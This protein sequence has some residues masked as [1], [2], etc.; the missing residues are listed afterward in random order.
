MEHRLR[1]PRG[2]PSLDRFA[3]VAAVAVP[4][5]WERRTG[6][7]GLRVRAATAEDLMPMAER[8]RDVGARRQLAPLAD[9]AEL[10]AWIARAPG[11]HVSDYLLAHDARGRLIG[12]VGVWDQSALKQM[13]V[14]GYSPRL[15]LARHAINLAAPLAGA[16]RL[17][18]PGGVLP[19]LAAVHLC[20]REPAV[21]RA[22]LL[23]AYGRHRGGRH[24]LLTL[25]LDVRDPLL[26]AT[27]GLLAQ[28]TLVHAYV[29]DGSTITAAALAARP[30]HHETA[31]V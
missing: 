18:A 7:A 12:F 22:L 25:G 14:V 31:L 15:A 23:A 5:L 29:A 16:P 6:V 4:L 21:L 11:L 28:S 17:P 30:L 24:A 8:W 19:A 3:T 1:G 26:G 27:R 9:A 20:A 10:A 13:R 2:S